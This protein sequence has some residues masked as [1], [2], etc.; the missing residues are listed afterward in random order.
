MK[1]QHFSIWLIDGLARIIF[2]FFAGVSA[3]Y[4]VFLVIHL[5]GFTPD[6]LNLSV[7]LPTSF[8]V[9]EEGT[10][11]DGDSISPITITE[12]NGKVTFENAPK[13]ISV[14]L[15]LC[16]LPL[17]ASLLYTLWLFK[18]FTKNVKLGR[19]FD[20]KNINHLKRIAYVI[21]ATW[22]YLQIGVVI[23]N[24]FIVSRFSFENL[25]FSYSHGSFGGLL[26]F[27]LFIWVLSHIFQKGAEIEEENLLT[28]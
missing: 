24:L 11:R 8:R 16:A 3:I 10:F 1:K 19:V 17:V 27:A 23:Y 9:L 18:G 22:L 28:V 4:S 12:A 2:W 15:P 21:T 20:P 14:V 7:E 6:E 26:I 5:L 13:L 25:Q